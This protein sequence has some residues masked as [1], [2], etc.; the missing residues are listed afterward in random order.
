MGKVG[1]KTLQANV[2]LTHQTL[3]SAFC[4]FAHNP[5]SPSTDTH[6]PVP[7]RPHL[8]VSPQT[9]ATN[10]KGFLC[11]HCPHKCNLASNLAVHM[12]RHTGAKP[13]SCPYCGESFRHTNSLHMHTRRHTGVKPFACTHCG[14]MSSRAWTHAV[15]MQMHE[16]M[17]KTGK[18]CEPADTQAPAENVRHS[19]SDDRMLCAT[20][21]AEKRTCLTCTVCKKNYRSKGILKTHM[22]IHT[23]EKPFA[24]KYCDYSSG[25]GSSLAR[26]MCVHTGAKSHK[27]TMCNK[28]FNTPSEL[29]VHTVIHSSAT[30]ATAST[31]PR[32]TE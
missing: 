16:R 27:C 31:A 20:E 19:T 14:K 4:A 11:P 23:K 15:H 5:L 22:R 25:D 8:P 24:C 7:I 17:S 30:P 2:L 6:N 18:S 3:F 21:E 32:I 29:R 13:Y 1:D 12:R 9:M 28:R 26:H 10:G